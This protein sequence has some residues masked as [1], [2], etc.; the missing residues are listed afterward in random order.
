VVK[1]KLTNAAEHKASE[2]VDDERAGGEGR[3][4]AVLN[5][6]LQAVARQSPGRTKH[7]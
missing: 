6:S 1:A 3:T 7:N 2:Y 5:E 4:G